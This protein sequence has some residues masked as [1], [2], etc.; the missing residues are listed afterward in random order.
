MKHAWTVSEV[1][2][3]L[4]LSPEDTRTLIARVF[5][6]P[7][8]LLSFQD[9]TTIR[10][11]AQRG[12]ET[13]LQPPSKTTVQKIGR[14]LVADD[15]GAKWNAKTGQTLLDLGASRSH[16]LQV[17]APR[18]DAHQ[19][20]ASAVS[21]EETDPPRAI[22]AYVEAVAADPK[23]ADA[24]INL[25]RLLHQCGRLREA[26]AHYVAA[27]VARPTDTTASYNLAVVLEDLGKL[28]EAIVRYRET[29]ELD[30]NV[31]D[32]YFNLARLYEKKGEKVSAIRHLKDYRR[33]IGR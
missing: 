14:E 9:L 13:L 26:E 25:G 23:H 10:T 32:A 18:R 21:L 29:I 6:R 19:L 16:W 7:R 22:E 33:L 17:T 20:F 3:M 28:D 1:A 5:E 2:V 27:L 15:G 30:P 8:D 31:T 12:L 4:G 11:A 24:H